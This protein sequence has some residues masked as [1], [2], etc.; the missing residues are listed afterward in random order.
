MG[1][2]LAE[3]SNFVKVGV[4]LTREG[5]IFLFALEDACFQL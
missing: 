1:V 3:P 4:D 5:C 2:W